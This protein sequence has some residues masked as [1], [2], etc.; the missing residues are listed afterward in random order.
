MDNKQAQATGR[1]KGL[2]TGT[3]KQRQAT[4]K[5]IGTVNQD[6]QQR[7]TTW[8]SNRHKRQGG[9]RDWQQGQANRD[10]QQCQANSDRQQRKAMG[11]GNRDRQPGQAVSH[12]LA[13]GSTDRQEDRRQG[14]Q[15][16]D[17]TGTKKQGT[18]D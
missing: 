11:T 14:R 15:H 5:A 18:R 6:K 17:T 9:K 10:R 8:T 13:T 12:L 4:K 2:A 3:G 1:Q 7:Q 16:G